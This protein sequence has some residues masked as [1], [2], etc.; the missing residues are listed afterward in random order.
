MKAKVKKGIVVGAGLA[1]MT[2]ARILS[3]AGVETV[4]LEKS[5][6]LGGRLAT[7]RLEAG[8]SF[9]HGAQYIRPRDPNFES[10]IKKTLASG[11]SSAWEPVGLS[12][13]PRAVVG[14]PGMSALVA[15]LSHDI[16]IENNTLV[17][18]VL[19]NRDGPVVISE[20]GRH[21]NADFVVVTVPGPQASNIINET[22]IKNSLAE[23]TMAP[24]WAVLVQST[25]ILSEAKD[26]WAAPN[27]EIAWISRNS[28]KPGRKVL[29]TS[30]VIHATPAWS[31]E[32]L[33]I[34]PQEVTNLLLQSFLR[35][36]GMVDD[37]I[38]YSTSHRWRFAQTENALGESFL[39]N[40]SSSI[41]FGGDWCLGPR[42]EDAYLSGKAIANHILT[43]I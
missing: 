2:A 25:Q 6:G 33:E 26:V 40:E 19:E 5:R 15:P 17:T 32:H 34:A 39:K 28:S 13:G 42:A 27:E 8:I 24:C 22:K 20:D 35:V 9:D 37:S 16:R 30:W 7:R 18:R 43:L 23:V 12:P 36:V 21:F 29:G 41:Y 31:R 3:D 4:I 38:I 11:H 1:G 14:T 10:F